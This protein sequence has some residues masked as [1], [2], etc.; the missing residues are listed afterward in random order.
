MISEDTIAYDDNTP[1]HLVPM[2]RTLLRWHLALI[3]RV[4]VLNT[5]DKDNNDSNHNNSKL[6]HLE[7]ITGSF[8]KKDIINITHSNKYKGFKFENTSNKKT[9]Q[10]DRVIKFPV[11]NND[12]CFQHFLFRPN[13]CLIYG[14][15]NPILRILVTNNTLFIVLDIGA[16]ITDIKTL[17]QTGLVKGDIIPLLNKEFF[18][19][20]FNIINLL[21]K[22]KDITQIVLSGHS[23][24][25]I[26][27]SVIGFCL[28]CITNSNY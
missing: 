21:I 11:E 28:L 9:L 12:I 19:E 4:L 23:Y 1:Y 10:F 20:L 13:K 14:C 16:R 7:C 2:Y 8:I 18:Y 5:L 15:E 22:E 17:S 6:T 24:G 27:S 3:S 25:F 26:L